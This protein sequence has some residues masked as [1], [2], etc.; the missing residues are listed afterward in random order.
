[1]V[2]PD[3]HFYIEGDLLKQ[4][5]YDFFYA[6]ASN[7]TMVYNS[8]FAF[9]ISFVGYINHKKGVL[10]RVLLPLCVYFCAT[11]AEKQWKNH[12]QQNNR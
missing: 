5:G 8:F 2:L 7:Y 1:M 6:L 12:P 11:Q 4:S 10:D 3:H 9:H